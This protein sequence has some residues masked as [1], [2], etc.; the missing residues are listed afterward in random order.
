[1]TKARGRFHVTSMHEDTYEGFVMD[2]R[3]DFDGVAS[4]GTWRIVEGS[5]T[6]ELEGIRGGSRGTEASYELEVELG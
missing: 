3:G 6:D 4:K 1:M 5:G 2:S